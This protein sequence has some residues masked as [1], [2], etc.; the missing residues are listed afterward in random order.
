MSRISEDTRNS[1]LSLIDSGLSSRK[2]E[3]RLEVGHATVNR[4]RAKFRPYAQKSR[5]GDQ[6][7]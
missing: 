3:A 7:S 2:V 6:P 4:E 1:I 5:A